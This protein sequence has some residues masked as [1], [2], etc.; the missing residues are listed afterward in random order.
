[1]VLAASAAG[2]GV[3]RDTIDGMNVSPSDE[4]Y[5]SGEAAPEPRR[6]AEGE[7]QEAGEAR[8]DTGDAPGDVIVVTVAVESDGATARDLVIDI[9]GRKHS[10]NVNEQSVKLPYTADF[11]VPMDAMFPLKATSVQAKAADGATGISCSIS[12]DGE[13][14]ATGESRGGQA[15]VACLKKFELGPG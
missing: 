13:V 7:G 2:C 6:E 14:V 8:E 15:A 5:P 3:V 4:P 11:E 1:V 9:D 10:Q 12:Y